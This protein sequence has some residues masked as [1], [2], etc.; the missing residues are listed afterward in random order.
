MAKFRD[1]KPETF[2]VLEPHITFWAEL[3]V[4]DNWRA[5]LLDR[6]INKPLPI[7]T[8]GFNRYLAEYAIHYAILIDDKNAIEDL[9]RNG[10]N[11]TVSGRWNMHKTPLELAIYYGRAGAVDLLMKYGA[12]LTK[13]AE[14][15]AHGLCSKNPLSFFWAMNE[16]ASNREVNYSKVEHLLE[17]SKRM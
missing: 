9:C 8:T 1:L 11:L 10:A 12:T 3:E 17:R 2:A 4:G 6:D 5:E 13:D 7:T 14:V 16:R 15:P